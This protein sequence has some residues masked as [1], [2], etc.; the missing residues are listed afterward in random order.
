MEIRNA[1]RG[2]IPIAILAPIL[3]CLAFVAPAGAVPAPFGAQLHFPVP[4]GDVGNSQLGVDAGLTV[5]S[6]GTPYLGVGADLV[7]HYWPASARY[8]SEFD[9]Y[10]R[11]TRFETLEGSTWAFKAYQL[12]GHLKLVAPVGRAYSPWLQLGAGLYALDLNLDERTSPGTFARTGEGDLGEVK[13]LPGAHIGVGFD[14][15]VGPTMAL[16]LDATFHRVWSE[17]DRVHAETRFPSFSGFTIGTHVMFG[18]E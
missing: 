8:T 6:M 4:A 15:R 10:L 18:V 11:R 1:R 14:V 16:G 5:T 13:L 12:T 7:Y 17:P 9:Q 2:R 3:A